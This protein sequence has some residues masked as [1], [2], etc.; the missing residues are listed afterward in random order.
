MIEKR[1]VLTENGYIYDTQD[2]AIC[3]TI[4]SVVKVLN[5]QHEENMNLRAKH[6]QLVILMKDVIDGL[7]RM[8]TRRF[9]EHIEK[10]GNVEFLSE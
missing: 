3:H 9:A 6:T 1:F 8:D 7:K 5:D 2:K 10:I 4:E